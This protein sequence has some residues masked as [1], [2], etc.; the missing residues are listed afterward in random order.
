MDCFWGLLRLLRLRLRL[1][2]CWSESGGEELKRG[3][4]VGEST[5]EEGSC[6]FDGD[7]VWKVGVEGRGRR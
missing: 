4:I 7:A 3:G 2:C 1:G 6:D 5:V